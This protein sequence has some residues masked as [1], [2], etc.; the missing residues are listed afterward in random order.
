[1]TRLAESASRSSQAVPQT[2]RQIARVALEG[3]ALKYRLV[4]ERLEE[5]TGKRLAPIHITGGLS[6]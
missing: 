4:L 1:M 2:K 5:L 6:A 3:I